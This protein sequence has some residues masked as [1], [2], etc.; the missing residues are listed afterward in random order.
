LRDGDTA[1]A[2]SGMKLRSLFVVAPVVVP[3]PDQFDDGSRQS[4]N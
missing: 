4:A 3:E 2:S 1:V